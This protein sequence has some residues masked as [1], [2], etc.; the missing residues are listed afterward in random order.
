MGFLALAFTI[1]GLIIIV[2]ILVAIIDAILCFLLYVVAFC[3]T[4]IISI[5]NHNFSNNQH[6]NNIVKQEPNQKT[7]D[8]EISRVFVILAVGVMVLLGNFISFYIF[9]WQTA[10]F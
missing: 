5:F 9:K 2:P 7:D 1:A 8:N 3:V 10:Y 6:S 4:G